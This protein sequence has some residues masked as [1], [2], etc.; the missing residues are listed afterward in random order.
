M[1]KKGHV[2]ATLTFFNNFYSKIETSIM[3]FDLYI[4]GCFEFKIK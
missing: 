4:L 1:Y 2:D 3:R